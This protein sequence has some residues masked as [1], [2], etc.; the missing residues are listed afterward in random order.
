MATKQAIANAVKAAQDYEEKNQERVRFSPVPLKK[1]W[2]RFF[3]HYSIIIIIV[4]CRKLM[5]TI[6]MLYSR[7]WV[8]CSIYLLKVRNVTECICSEIPVGV[9]LGPQASRCS[10]PPPTLFKLGTNC[11]ESAQ[12]LFDQAVKENREFTSS[13]IQSMP[14]TV[15]RSPTIS[16]SY[17]PKRS[18]SD[19]SS[20]QF[21]SSHHLPHTHS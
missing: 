8:N 4:C 6:C 18:V 17:Q 11:L 20:C 7:L 15:T 2:C 1:N 16:H 13:Q 14:P 12:R 10:V 19:V 9:Y 21:V 5:I 3:V